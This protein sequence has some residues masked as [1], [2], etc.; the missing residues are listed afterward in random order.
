MVVASAERL[1]WLTG[2]QR[3]NKTMPNRDGM[4]IKKERK[5]KLQSLASS[6]NDDYVVKK[7]TN[8][9]WTQLLVDEPVRR[10]ER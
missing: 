1:I 4:E 5:M 7:E 9:Q 6:E 8:P 10:G 2:D 3:R